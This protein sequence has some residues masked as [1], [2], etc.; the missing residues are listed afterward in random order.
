MLPSIPCTDPQLLPGS[1]KNVISMFVQ[2]DRIIIWRSI[3][4]QM[5]IIQCDP[6]TG[7]VAFTRVPSPP[8]HALHNAHNCG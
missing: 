8:Q 2:L 5:P 6:T 3:P 1:Q 4:F 7:T